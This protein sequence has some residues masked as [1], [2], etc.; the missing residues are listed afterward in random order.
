MILFEMVDVYNGLTLRE[1]FAFWAELCGD[2]DDYQYISGM[3]D[4]MKW[5]IIYHISPNI[6]FVGPLLG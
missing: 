1:T 5:Y 6:F 4:S 2:D 3:V